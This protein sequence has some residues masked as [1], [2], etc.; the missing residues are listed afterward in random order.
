MLCCSDSVHSS[1]SEHQ[2]PQAATALQALQFGDMKIIDKINAS[3]AAKE[4]FFSFE[5]FPPRT[6]E[7]R[8]A[9]TQQHMQGAN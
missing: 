8:L 7:V 3:I 6:E 4:T 9:A 1:H 5:F 2:P